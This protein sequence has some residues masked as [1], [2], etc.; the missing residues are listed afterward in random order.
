MDAARRRP[1]HA[2]LDRL[3]AI[4]GR[5]HRAVKSAVLTHRNIVAA[6][7]QAEAWFTPRWN[8]GRHRK[9][10]S[11]AA[12]PLYHI[13][14]LTLCLLAFRQGAHMT[15]IPNPRDFS[16]FIAVLKKRPFHM[17]PAVNTLFNAL[18]SIPIQLDR[19][20]AVVRFASGGMAASEG[21]AKLWPESRVA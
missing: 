5:H 14:A 18:L 7:L 16:K 4:H 1:E 6:T 21:T 11:I 10:N 3:P 8:A 17:L 15:L 9:V 13:F 20:L 12:L 19:L 2:R